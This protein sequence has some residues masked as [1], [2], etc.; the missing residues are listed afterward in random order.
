MIQCPKCDNDTRTSGLITAAGEVLLAGTIS[1]D[2]Q[3]IVAQV[4]TAVAGPGCDDG[5]PCTWDACT[6]EGACAHGSVGGTAA[7]TCR[8]AA[9]ALS[10]C[11]GVVPRGVARRYAQ[12][13]GLVL[14]AANARRAAASRRPARRAIRSLARATAATRSARHR[15]EIAADCAAALLETLASLRAA[16][17]TLLAG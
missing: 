1:A 16:A 10:D 9:P 4:C 11:G 7:V 3:P 14:R 2:P 8:F 13:R 6:P 15:Q 5:D 12:A 17:R